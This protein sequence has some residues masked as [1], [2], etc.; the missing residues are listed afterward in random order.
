MV[1]NM[2]KKRN[3]RGFTMAELL[4]VVAI[5]TI[6]SG[7]AFIAVQKHEESLSQA[8]CNSIAKEIFIAAQNHL[9][10]AE[11]QGY[12]GIDES[13]Y[14]TKVGAKDVDGNDAK[15]VYTI[16]DSGIPAAGTMLNLMLPFGAIDETVRSGG[17]YLIHYQ[18]NP[19]LV[20]NVYYC[21]PNG[22]YGGSLPTAS[23]T[24]GTTQSGKI[25]DVVVGWYGG[26]DAQATGVTLNAPS[27]SVKNE[28]RLTVVV[29]TKDVVPPGVTLS[30]PY[31]LK[32]L[33]SNLDGTA[34]AAIPL[35][36]KTSEGTSTHTARVENTITNEYTVILDDIT[37]NKDLHF[38]KINEDGTIAKMQGSV[39]FKPGEDIIVSAV[40]YNNA[41]LSNIV[42]SSEETVN[43]LFA[44]VEGDN[45][46][47]QS[48]LTIE[49][50]QVTTG[51]TKEVTAK[52]ANFRH[53]ENLD[54]DISGLSNEIGIKKAEQIEDLVWA[55]TTDEKAF[56][57]KIASVSS[58]YSDSN[59]VTVYKF[60][61][62]SSTPAAAST[63]GCYY[64]I[65]SDYELTY[66]GVY[67]DN[68][69]SKK[70]HSIT[71][72]KV[73]GGLGANDN[74]VAYSGAGGLFGAPTG[75]LTIKNLALIDFDIKASGDAGALVGTLPA[76]SSVTNVIAYNTSTFDK[77]TDNK[78][79]TTITSNGGN[80]GGLIGLLKS[81]SDKK[82]QV[83]N[84]AAALVVSSTGGNAG[85]LIG[86]AEGVTITACYSGGHTENGQYTGVTTGTDA[87]KGFNVSAKT[88][89]AGGLIGVSGATVNN[90]YSTCSVTGATAGGFVGTSTG[91]VTNCY[92]TG[93]VFGTDTEKVTIG[94]TEKTIPKDGAFAY[95]VSSA[96]DCT[97]FDIINERLDA[98]TQSYQ[99]LT[100]LGQNK[101]PIDGGIVAFDKDAS[102]YN[103]FSGAESAWTAASPYD[104]TLT[105]Y[106]GTGTGN[107]RTSR[108]NLQNVA[109]LGEDLTPDAFVATHYG[110]WP[111]PEIFV[112]NT[113]G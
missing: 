102:A 16:V 21:S 77:G 22:K 84:C 89:V 59:K 62:N 18:A 74:E 108:Y 1:C 61:A 66:D 42:Y 39:A 48:E 53:L 51:S 35:S 40:V 23:I 87:G 91:A 76:G 101:T 78:P 58:D 82:T 36:V 98:T 94:G 109:R 55:S 111:A 9:T 75:T 73:S 65:S 106:Y 8:E 96:T 3:N 29:N 44:D 56:T 112:L 81:E 107:A 37:S 33:I 31:S 15:D 45:A 93:Q 97:Y 6:L 63:G 57:T 110:D 32:L 5:I 92:A 34:M 4:I 100:P 99:Y 85:G 24:P 49:N 103:G 95:S 88:G 67:D 71:G 52:I 104:P 43:S 19:A 90:C 20:L 46:S 28:E 27:I 38:A 14:G 50:G 2:Q 79:K 83:T 68:A 80:V 54:K 70:C 12:L 41:A 47:T 7:V 25:G 26:A 13:T 30:S 69:N 113:K 11:S 72:V 105:A 10:M 86:T 17:H 64:P 60:T